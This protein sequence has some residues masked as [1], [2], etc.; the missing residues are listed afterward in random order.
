MDFTKV[1]GEGERKGERERN[2]SHGSPD[3][4]DAANV[5]LDAV[6][7]VSLTQT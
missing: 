7:L 1:Q 3:S 2:L 6:M 5:G 4:Q